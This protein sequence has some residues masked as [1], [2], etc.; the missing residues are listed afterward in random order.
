MLCSKT[1]GVS[2]LIITVSGS[3]ESRGTKSSNSLASTSSFSERKP[4]ALSIID[5]KK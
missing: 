1:Y 3:K 2:N 5:I 4:K